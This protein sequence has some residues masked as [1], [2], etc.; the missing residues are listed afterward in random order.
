MRVVVTVVIVIGVL[1]A[2]EIKPSLRDIMDSAP[3]DSQISIIVKMLE[4]ADLSGFQPYE[5]PEMVQYLKDFAEQSQES[6]LQYLSTFEG[7]YSNLRTFW[8]LN[9]FCVSA[10]SSVIESLALRNDIDYLIESRVMYLESFNPTPA[11]QSRGIEWNI[12]KIKAPEAWSLGTTGEGVVVGIIDSGFEEDH[13]ALQGKWRAE[14]GWYDALWHEPNPDDRDGHGT[15][16]TGIICGGDGFGPSSDDIGVAPGVS[17]IAARAFSGDDVGSDISL[18]DCCQWMAGLAE[19]GLEPQ[20]INNS[21]SWPTDCNPEE[22]LFLDVVDNWCYLSIVPVFAIGNTGNCFY[23]EPFYGS[24]VAPGNYPHTIGVGA[25]DENDEIAGFSLWGPAPYTWPWYDPSWWLRSDWDLIKPNICAPGSLIRSSIPGNDYGEKFGTSMAAP[26]VTGTVALILQIYPELS[27]EE[28]YS[29]LIDNVDHPPQG[30]L[31][32]NNKYGWGRVNAEDVSIWPGAAL[33]WP[34]SEGIDVEEGETYDITFDGL[35][36]Y[37]IYLARAWLSRDGGLSWPFFLGDREF[38]LQPTQILNETISWTVTQEPTEEAKIKIVLYTNNGCELEDISNYDFLIRPTKPGQVHAISNEPWDLISVTWQDQSQYSDGFEMEKTNE[39]GDSELSTLGYVTEYTD[40]DVDFF[41]SYKYR[42]RSIDGSIVSKWAETTGFSTPHWTVGDGNLAEWVEICWAADILY[43]FFTQYYEQ[44]EICYRHST[45]FGVS[46]SDPDTVSTEPVVHSKFSVVGHPNGQI[47]LAYVKDIG[48]GKDG[49]AVRFFQNGVWGNSIE[50]ERPDEGYW[51]PDVDIGWYP[52]AESAMVCVLWTVEDGINYATASLYNV[53]LESE[54]AYNLDTGFFLHQDAESKEIV[55][56]DRVFPSYLANGNW[57]ATYNLDKQGQNKKI[58]TMWANSL[59][60]QEVH[61]SQN[62]F[63]DMSGSRSLNAFREG[64]SLKVF[65]YSLDSDG[66]IIW[67]GPTSIYSFQDVVEESNY[68]EVAKLG[69]D[70]FMVIR[71]LGELFLMKRVPGVGPPSWQTEYWLTTGELPPVYDFNV[72]QKPIEH[73]PAERPI[74]FANV[75]YGIPEIGG[76][77]STIV[78]KRREFPR[79]DISDPTSIELPIHGQELMVRIN[80]ENF[81][82]WHQEGMIYYTLTDNKA[83]GWKKPQILT[84]GWAPTT[85]VLPDS[86]GFEV[87]FLRGKPGGDT[88]FVVDCTIASG[89]GE[90]EPVWTPATDEIVGPVAVSRTDSAVCLTMQGWGGTFQGDTLFTPTDSLLR[91]L[92]V[93]PDTWGLIINDTLERVA[94]ETPDPI[95]PWKA[96]LSLTSPPVATVQDMVFLLT[97]ADKGSPSERIELH[98]FLDGQWR[99]RTIAEGQAPYDDSHIGKDGMTLRFFWKQGEIGDIYYRTIYAGDT[100]LMSRITNLSNT[101]NKDSRDP[102]FAGQRVFWSE[103]TA[104]GQYDIYHVSFV[105][106]GDPERLV[107][108]DWG[109]AFGPE[110]LCYTVGGDYYESTVYLSTW[111]EEETA[112][113]QTALLWNVYSTGPIPEQVWILG[114]TIPGPKTQQ[115][116]GF[117]EYDEGKGGSADIGECLRYRITDL[118]PQKDYTIGFYIY[119]EE[120]T[121]VIEKFYAD[122]ELLKIINSEPGE[123]TYAEVEIPLALYEQDSAIDLEITREEGPT[124][125]LNE[126]YVFGNW[127]QGGGGAQGDGQLALIPKVF[128]IHSVKPIPMRNSGEVKLAIPRRSNVS[129]KMFDVTGRLVNEVFDGTLDPGYHRFV[130]DCTD[131]ASAPQNP[132]HL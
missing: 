7:E 39:E 129:L 95:P 27:V 128:D 76:G 125:V 1:G 57:G 30:Y 15:H 119:H 67:T 42:V 31:Y 68:V 5:K 11:P 90:P 21:W 100:V 50:L 4:K 26:H 49:V 69:I 52:D 36:L 106:T 93:D 127:R 109:D 114:D 9:G 115:R 77:M 23:E 16:V 130:L 59:V 44:F 116:D 8:I 48:Q 19:Y 112:T 124:A 72:F 71:D 20:V 6:T 65:W 102:W 38:T 78:F 123:E 97:V 105:L 37:G 86:S 43:V 14:S 29:Y 60:P 131:E 54:S 28:I 101:P 111:L 53:I 89:F 47:A 92:Q 79:G 81:L 40:A 83:D 24:A 96:R 104:E 55:M 3:P 117:K 94:I 107:E 118:N 113:H 126:M 17:F 25:T 22:Y 80:S 13:D 103:E 56:Q 63:W 120:S 32:P 2:G 121:G 87:F 84:E 58:E 70:E 61:G 45:N 110:V 62:I 66:S 64:N 18:L 91:T 108:T 34:N 132:Y 46:F 98:E 10:I 51:N 73:V 82:I 74:L 75:V 99:T 33:D 85:S 35:S 41:H 12:N 88:L 122:G